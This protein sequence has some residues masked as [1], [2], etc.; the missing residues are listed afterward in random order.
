MDCDNDD[1]NDEENYWNSHY[2]KVDKVEEKF[3]HP[4]AS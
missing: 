3:E 2:R 4:L 1:A